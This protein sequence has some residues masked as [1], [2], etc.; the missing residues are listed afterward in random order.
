MAWSS[1][2]IKNSFFSVLGA[3]TTPSTAQD[4]IDSVRDAMLEAMGA[5]GQDIYQVLHARIQ[6]AQELET[7][8][9]ARSD[10][11][12]ALSALRGELVAARE[13]ERISDMFRGGDLS[14]GLQSRPSPLGMR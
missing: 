8:W 4:K 2:R 9:Y 3:S 12:V 10:L 7:L 1:Q 5:E 13:L 11:M 14:P 6:F